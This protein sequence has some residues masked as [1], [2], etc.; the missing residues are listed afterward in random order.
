ME[1]QRQPSEVD[2]L[3]N[4]ILHPKME[5]TLESILSYLVHYYPIIKNKRNIELLTISFIKS[6]LSKNW[7]FRVVDAFKFIMDSK[8]KVSLPTLPFNEFYAAIFD[9][10][11]FAIETDPSVFPRVIPIIT[12][13]LLSKNSR[14]EINSFPNHSY[15]INTID[16][17]FKSILKSSLI[18]HFRTFIDSDLAFSCLAAVHDQFSNADFYDFIKVKSDSPECLLILMFQSPIGLNNGIAL[19]DGD[20]LGSVLRQLNRFAFLFNKLIE[21]Y[22][23]NSILPCLLNSSAIID[24]YSS[25]LTSNGLLPK[26]M[27]LIDEDNWQLIKFNYFS[28]IILFDGILTKILKS[29]N[30]PNDSCFK[31]FNSILS[32]LFKLSFILDKIGSG[33]FESYNF[34][35][36]SVLNCLIK[37]NEQ[38]MA[39]GIIIDMIQSQLNE[40]QLDFTLQ[41]INA[42]IPILDKE[43]IKL[44]ILP[45]IKDSLNSQD[46][47]S[48]LVH[49]IMLKYLTMNHQSNSLADDLSIYIA[50]TLNQFPNNLTF[51]ECSNIISRIMENLSSM[52]TTNL[53]DL[54]KMISMKS[55]LSPIK[56]KFVNINGERTQIDNKFT[57]N[58]SSLVGLLINLIHFLPLE[59][60]PMELTSVRNMITSPYLNNIDSVQLFNHLWDEIL[61]CNKYFPSKGE[62]CLNWWYDNVNGL[63]KL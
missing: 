17:Y 2:F 48:S 22:P 31:I 63:P 44:R 61:I 19:L 43:F 8:F 35:V 14:V 5:T 32:S 4:D 26:I 62:I 21:N 56:L 15:S 33:D 28:I 3:L 9:G 11:K 13:C 12:G 54:I 41:V 1:F 16:S 25:N 49:E 40:S 7:N 27:K 51:I 36:D 45:I 20:Q 23:K 46:K 18:S 38:R 30:K 59:S 53:F 50:S 47:P 24:Q 42:L 58:K 10:I 60:L 6:P 39:Q 55:D 34:V 57:S 52:E 29:F 37:F